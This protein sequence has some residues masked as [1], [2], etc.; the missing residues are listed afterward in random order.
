MIDWTWDHANEAYNSLGI[1]VFWSQRSWWN[2][3]GVTRPNRGRLESAISFS[4]FSPRQVD[5][6][7]CCQLRS[8]DDRR[9]FFKLIPRL[10]DTTGRTTGL[11]T[12]LITGWASTFVYGSSSAVVD[13]CSICLA[14]VQLVKTIICLKSHCLDYAVGNRCERYFMSH[15]MSTGTS[16]GVCIFYENIEAC[17][18]RHFGG[19]NRLRARRQATH[20]SMN[21]LK[22]IQ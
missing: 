9:Q 15:C 5:R 8:T 10:H 19:Q 4:F 21:H 7:K 22:P 13:T 3:T 14:E 12:G 17:P 11:T 2:S 16:I 6:S 18:E 20:F 1:V